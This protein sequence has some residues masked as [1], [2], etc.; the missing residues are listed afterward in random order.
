MITKNKQ[1]SRIEESFLD[2]G[3]KLTPEKKII[4][5]VITDSSDLMLMKFS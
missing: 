1:I 3:I 5:K 2:K 4:A